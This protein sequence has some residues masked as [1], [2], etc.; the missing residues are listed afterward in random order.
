MALLERAA[1]EDDARFELVAF[2]ALA[3]LAAFEVL[4]AFA[5]LL[6]A[7]LLADALFAAFAALR[8]LPVVADALLLAEWLAASFAE[9]EEF[10]PEAELAELV[11]LL[12]APVLD[13]APL[14]A[15]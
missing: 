1:F 2:D 10:C 7:E 8:A 4:A 12:A 13:V 9:L 3:W 15:D 14:L 5:A 11:L 6:L